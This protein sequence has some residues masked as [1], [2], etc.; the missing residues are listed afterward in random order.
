MVTL[1]VFVVSAVALAHLTD[2]EFLLAENEC[3]HLTVLVVSIAWCAC[4]CYMIAV[5][6]LKECIEDF[7]VDPDEAVTV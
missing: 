6:K 7:E 4:M 2:T 3:F 5:L 1:I